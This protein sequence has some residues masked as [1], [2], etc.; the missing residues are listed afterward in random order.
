M[1]R[2]ATFAEAGALL[3]APVQPQER[4]EAL[5]AMRLPLDQQQVLERQR[6]ELVWFTLWDD[7]DQDGDIVAVESDGFRQQVQIAHAPVRLAVPRPRGGT[8]VLRGVQQGGGGITVA[9]QSGGGQI[10]LPPLMVGQA[11]TIPVR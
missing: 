6:S 5:K 3:L 10:G 7:R 1:A 2:Q 4:A 8:V 11:V 9:V